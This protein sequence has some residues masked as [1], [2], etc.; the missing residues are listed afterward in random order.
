MPRGRIAILIVGAFCLS[1][2]R[3]HAAVGT[4]TQKGGIRTV[5]VN[6]DKGGSIQAALDKAQGPLVI[7]VRGLCHETVAVTHDD[8]T[9]RGEDPERDGIRGVAA[10]PLPDAALQIW[11]AQRVHLENLSI[12][13]SPNIGVGAWYST[14]YMERCHLK[15]NV[16]YG[17]HVSAMSAVLGTELEI[18][19]NANVGLNVQRSSTSTCLGC[20]LEAN[21]SWAAWA[22]M[23]G[24]VGLSDSV[25]SG[26]PLSSSWGSGGGLVATAGGSAT[27]DCAT[28]DTS[29]PCSLTASDPGTGPPWS[30]A[31]NAVDS[32]TV[33]LRGVSP[34]QGAIHADRGNVQLY[35]SRQAWTGM[36]NHLGNFATMTTGGDSDVGPTELTMP[37]EVT[38]FARLVLREGTVVFPQPDGYNLVLR[39]LGGGDAYADPGVIVP[40]PVGGQVMGCAHLPYP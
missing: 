35:G 6:C 20:R 32:G 10:D 16:S 1:P 8:V 7:E 38:E 30:W 31:V 9:L 36:R 22:R 3:A 37:T 33:T 14:V 27:L 2:A 25:V 29:Y 34:F 13:D 12:S 40:A 5:R 39:C 21:G 4:L 28:E 23:G 19:N 24:I 18:S 17:L 26:G 15:A 11:Y